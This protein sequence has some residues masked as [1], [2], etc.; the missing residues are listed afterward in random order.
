MSIA[1]RRVREAGSSEEESF[2]AQG[3][4]QFNY[5]VEDVARA[6]TLYSALL[7]VEPYAD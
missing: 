4:K 5:P 3:I 7:G 2:L 6:K 1:E